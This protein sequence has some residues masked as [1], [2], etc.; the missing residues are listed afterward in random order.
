[1]IKCYFIDDKEGDYQSVS[2]HK[3]DPAFKIDHLYHEGF[4]ITAEEL[5]QRERAAF[6]AARETHIVDTNAWDNEHF[7]QL[8]FKTAD[9]YLKQR[10][11]DQAS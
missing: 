8:K 3:A 10:K 11:D 9:D 1:M 4:F 2:L 7:P 5:E 6:E